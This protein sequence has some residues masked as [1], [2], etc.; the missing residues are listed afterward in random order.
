M[1]RKINKYDAPGPVGVEYADGSILRVRFDAEGKAYFE[2]VTQLAASDVQPLPF[3]SAV[4]IDGTQVLTI[5]QSLSLRVL[6]VS[7]DGASVTLEHDASQLGQLEPGA[8]YAF[9]VVIAGPPVDQDLIYPRHIRRLTNIWSDEL[10]SQSGDLTLDADLGNNIRIGMSGNIDILDI[11]NASTD[12]G[13]DHGKIVV[14]QQ[15]GDTNTCTFG[16]AFSGINDLTAETGANVRTVYEWFYRPSMGGVIQAKIEVLKK[17]GAAGGAGGFPIIT[18]PGTVVG[19]AVPG[20]TMS[21]VGFSATGATDPDTYEWQRDTGSGFSA[22]GGATSEDYTATASDQGYNIRRKTTATNASG[23][24]SD[25]TAAISISALR[26]APV[27]RSQ[28]VNR[29]S[30]Y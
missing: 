22:I 18:D 23:S 7:E 3:T 2:G 14:W 25:F 12:L 9:P 4:Y 20:A 28:A 6:A 19:D 27:V 8:A 21:V 15:S 17:G 13:Y 1:A 29:S 30:N 10:Q 5:G 24:V 26:R 16:S 11:L